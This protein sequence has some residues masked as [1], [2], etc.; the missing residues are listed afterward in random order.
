MATFYKG[1]CIQLLKQTPAKSIN[2]IY[3]NPPFGTT[4]CWWDEKLDWATIFL[5]CF[6]VLKDDGMLV[7]PYSVYYFFVL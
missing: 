7:I 5:E 3:W 2:M 4:A 6:R 1:D